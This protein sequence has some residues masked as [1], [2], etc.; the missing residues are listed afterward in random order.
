[1]L[2]FDTCIGV[3]MGMGRHV[4]ISHVHSRKC[5]SHDIVHM[6]VNKLVQMYF[7]QGSKG[8]NPSPYIICVCY[9]F[10][11]SPTACTKLENGM[12]FWHAFF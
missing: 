12:N 4:M 10:C 1:M 7:N 8:V 11:V 9:I 6:Q 2:Y 3:N 5:Y